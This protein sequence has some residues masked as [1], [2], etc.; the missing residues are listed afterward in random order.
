VANAAGTVMSPGEF[1]NSF[2]LVD[3]D[4]RLVFWDEGFAQEFRFAAP[5]LKP[6][7]PYAEIARA[8]SNDPRVKALLA[9][10]GFGDLDSLFEHGIS[11][12]SDDLRVEYRTP[13]G[14]VILVEQYKTEAGGIRRFAR[15]VTEERDEGHRLTTVY[16]RLDAVA[17]V[18]TETR[19]TPD[20]NYA[21]QPIDEPLRRLL[22]LPSAFVGQD[23]VVF[24]GRMV[25]LPEDHARNHAQLERAAQ[26]LEVIEQDYCVRDGNERKRWLRHA[27]MPRRE[28]DG[29]VIFS[30]VLR[31]VTREK[32]AEDQLDLLHSVVVRSSDAIVIFETGKD[33]AEDARILYVNTKFTDLFGGTAETLVGQ[34]MGSL[35][36]NDFENVGRKILMAALERDDGVPVEYQAK[37]RDGRVFWL[38]VRVK[39]VQKLDDGAIR[40]VVISRDVSKRRQAQDDMQ[41]AKEQAEAGNR[42][43][44]EF[45]ANMSH[46]LRTPLNA[47]IGFTELIQQSVA[48]TGWT[49]EYDEYLTDVSDSGHHLLALINAILELSRV[50]AG[51]L[52]LNPAPLDLGELVRAALGPLSD[53]ARDGGIVLSVDLPAGAAEVPGDYL[54][55]KQA[56]QNVASNA[57]KFTPRGGKVDVTVR[58]DPTAAIIEVAD[59]GCGIPAADRERVLLPF[60]QAASSLS[61]QHGGSGLGLSIAHRLCT[62]H[63]GALT[64]DSVEGQGTTVRISLPR[65]ES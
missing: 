3:A 58:L 26:T 13:E 50:D 2:A 1:V 49:P 56:L 35:A 24:F 17:G 33:A 6:G 28:P 61:R 32:E 51:Q 20:G 22:E 38:E 65:S 62:L 44:S 12:L 29:T 63:G 31:D 4:G 21:Y 53:T 59:T 39:I 60:V 48:E 30:G 16:R 36:A 14:R 8:T 23:A 52:V 37:A 55:L 41:H 57:I 11:E 27:M 5:L 45:L 42:A 46:E 10:S 18:F 9:K 64:L 47:I 40:W 54:K 19:R 34:P 25:A 15:D 7:V 43:K